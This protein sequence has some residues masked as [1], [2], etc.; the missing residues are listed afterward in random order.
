MNNG[1]DA[2]HETAARGVEAIHMIVEQR[3][4]LLA[5][6]ERMKT[7]IMLLR[8]KN[9]QLEGRLA[10]ATVE[11]DHY[12]RY[13]TELTSKLNDIQMLIL[14]C[15]EAAKHAAYRPQVGIAAPTAQDI[16]LDIDAK[17]IEGLI[18]RLPR[19]GGEPN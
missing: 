10:Q 13:C 15:V 19:N 8:E 12:M 2:L 7:D 3:D 14:N 9:T 5:D 18:Q 17:S 6:S 1:G 16:A 4:R 11:R